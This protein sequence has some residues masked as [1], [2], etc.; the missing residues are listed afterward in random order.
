V[1]AAPPPPSPTLGKSGTITTALLA[2]SSGEVK[3]QR[4]YHETLA[5]AGCMRSHAVPGYSDPQP[6]DTPTAHGIK[7]GGNVD[8][9][10]LRVQTAQKACQPCLPGL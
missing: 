4:M 10:S 8:S 3:L 7:M 9:N 1:E 6:I 5:Y 2:A